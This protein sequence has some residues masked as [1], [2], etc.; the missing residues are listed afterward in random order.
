MCIGEGRD[1]LVLTGNNFLKGG[2]I[3]RGK[4]S[5]KVENKE[6]YIERGKIYRVF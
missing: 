3:C 6:N 5:T 1:N 4:K 2:I